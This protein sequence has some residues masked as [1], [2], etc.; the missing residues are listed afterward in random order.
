MNNPITIEPP[1][2][3]YV[4]KIG[5]VLWGAGADW[6]E[7]EQ[8]IGEYVRD[9]MR[10]AALTLNAITGKELID[11]SPTPFGKNGIIPL[12]SAYPNTIKALRYFLIDHTWFEK[13]AHEDPYLDHK[14]YGIVP[15][16]IL[17]KSISEYEATV[18]DSGLPFPEL[19]LDLEWNR[20]QFG[21]ELLRIPRMG[22]LLMGSGYNQGCCHNDGSFERKYA[23][24]KLSNGDWLYVAFWEWFNK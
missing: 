15:V 9:P 5:D 14:V 1:E 2:E 10:D 24:L 4:P 17:L 21:E 8:K 22:K 3:R 20:E 16:A 7:P 12:C 6:A 19:V 11:Y 18:R 13:A 23:K